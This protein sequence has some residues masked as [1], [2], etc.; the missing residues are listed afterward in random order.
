MGRAGT[1]RTG[2]G[3]AAAVYGALQLAAVALALWLSWRF[4]V[5]SMATTAIALAPT[6]PAAF[7]A[8]LA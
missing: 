5:A 3:R 4:E 2:T 8:W 7:L 1:G 6:M